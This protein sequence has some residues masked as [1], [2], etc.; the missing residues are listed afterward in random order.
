MVDRSI[1]RIVDGE[2]MEAAPVMSIFDTI[3]AWFATGAN[4]ISNADIS[5]SAAIDGAKLSLDNNTAWAA[6][7]ATDGSHKIVSNGAQAMRLT[8]TS[9]DRIDM[10][11]E[12]LQL[13]NQAT[14]MSICDD[15]DS[16][17]E[18]AVYANIT[19]AVGE[20]GKFNTFTRT[21]YTTYYIFALYDSAAQ[22]KTLVFTPN[23]SAVDTNFW[24]AMATFNAAVGGGALYD[25]A[26]LV[27]SVYNVS[28]SGTHELWQPRVIPGS[29]VATSAFMPGIPLIKYGT[30]V[31]DDTERAITGVG[32][33]PD[34]V[35]VWSDYSPAGSWVYPS[36]K[37]ADMASGTSMYSGG[38]HGASSGI[39]TLD[40]DGFTVY[41]NGWTNASPYNYYYVAIRV[42]SIS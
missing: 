41:G 17:Y 24:T 21:T 5:T 40:A 33:R 31:G 16:T 27:G 39:K 38:S 18:W 9:V 36:L 22:T 6:Q 7:H 30:Y 35:F 4:G 32:F 11:A 25:Y 1:A 37:T 29:A 10:A 26:K 2:D 28:Y 13:Q 42:H 12:I 8:W 20:S 23:Y 3:V 19:N 15:G 34:I 14:E